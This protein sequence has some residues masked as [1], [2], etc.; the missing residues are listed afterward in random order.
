VS[1]IDWAGLMRAGM[2]GLKLRPEE[3]WRLSPLELMLMLGRE[4]GVGALGRVRLDELARA[5]PDSTAK[6]DKGQSDE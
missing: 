4:Q 6:S 3:F 2:T 1:E 5:Y